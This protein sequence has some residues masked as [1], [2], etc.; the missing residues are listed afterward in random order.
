M[1]QQA[2]KWLTRNLFC[3]PT[4]NWTNGKSKHA[5]L[6]SVAVLHKGTALLHFSTQ[7]L[8]LALVALQQEV[9]HIGLHILVG[10]F[11]SQLAPHAC[12]H[13]LKLCIT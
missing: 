3:F 8:C 9:F 2:S 7:G 6:K 1:K 12:Q 4:G 13:L 11:G 10:P 5:N